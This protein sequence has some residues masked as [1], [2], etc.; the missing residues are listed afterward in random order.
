MI[1]GMSVVPVEWHC[2][3]T[4]NMCLILPYTFTLNCGGNDSNKLYHTV[5]NVCRMLFGN[6]DSLKIAFEF[7][8]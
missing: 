8:A 2:N 1:H 7:V 3:I 6:C 4:V 5:F